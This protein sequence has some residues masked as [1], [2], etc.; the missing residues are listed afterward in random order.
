MAKAAAKTTESAWVVATGNSSPGGPWT[1]K[2]MTTAVAARMTAAQ[3]IARRMRFESD[4]P[5]T[6]AWKRKKRMGT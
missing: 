1:V 2:A 6:A 4:G 5:R 3:T